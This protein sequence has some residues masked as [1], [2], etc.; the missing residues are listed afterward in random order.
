MRPG[1]PEGRT[2]DYKRHGTTS[3]FAALDVAS[4]T[5]IGELQRRHRSIEFRTFLDRIDVEVPPDLEAH[6]VLD[7]YGTHKTPLI[8]R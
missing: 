6:L 5:V 4:G 1:Q 3:L 7:N 2:H 8:R